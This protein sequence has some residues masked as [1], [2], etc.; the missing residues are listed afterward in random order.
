MTYRV[1]DLFAGGGGFSTGFQLARI[2]EKS[3]EIVR[4]VELNEDACSTLENHLGKEKVIQGDVTTEVVKQR[5]I[6]ECNDID[7]I[8]GG[9]PCQTYSLAGPSR[10]GKKEMRE[11]LKNDP[12]NT[13]FKHFFELV[14]LIKPKVVVFENVEGI[15]SKQLE[16]NEGEMG[17]SAKQT[18]AI[19]VICDELESMGYYLAL[20]ANPNYRYQVLNAA[21]F[22]VAQQRK[23]VIIIA[24]RNEILNPSPKRLNR[25]GEIRK[26]L[27]E[28]I[29]EVPVVLPEIIVNNIKKLLKIDIIVNDLEKSVMAFVN[30]INNIKVK[31]SDRPEVNSMEFLKIHRYLNNELKGIVQVTG[32][33]FEWLEQFL[34]GYNELLSYYNAVHLNTSLEHTSRKH[35]FRDIVIF[36]LMRSGT[37]SAQFMNQDSELFDDFLNQVY[38][39]DKT[40]HVDTYVKHSWDKTSNTILSH[41]EKDGLKFIHPDQP[42]TFTPYE[43]ALIQSFPSNYQFSG[44][45]NAKYRQIGNAVPPLMA[46]SIGE[47]VIELLNAIDNKNSVALLR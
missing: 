39:Y 22:G 19:D 41:M 21:D 1:L 26:T 45:R 27:R 2:N 7:V 3:F 46:K 6:Q 38:P 8:I 20:K 34:R 16:D 14:D 32:N 13:L 36:S 29:G 9:P 11:A 44:G 10:S 18:L 31:Y 5:I 35:N 17:L 30:S 12:R 25:V 24:N 28:V 40:K 33:K 42:R 4:A 43:A 47:S 23:R 37:S 15:I